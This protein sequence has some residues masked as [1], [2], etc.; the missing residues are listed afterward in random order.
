MADVN[1]SI[2]VTR[3]STGH[4][5]VT[6]TVRQGVASSSYSYKTTQSGLKDGTALCRR[7]ALKNLKLVT[8]A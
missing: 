1:E 2:R 5:I 7:E 4:H 8:E 6:V 3:P